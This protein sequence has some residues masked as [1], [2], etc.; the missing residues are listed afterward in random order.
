MI[1]ARMLETIPIP[2]AS[3]MYATVRTQK[4][5]LFVVAATAAAGAVAMLCDPLLPRRR[6][7][8]R[9]NAPSTTFLVAGT[10]CWQADWRH[11][12][13]ERGERKCSRSSVRTKDR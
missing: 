9:Q 8:R 1:D 13:R 12:A 5:A 2:I 10:A 6:V 7:Y 3:M 4:P 11:L